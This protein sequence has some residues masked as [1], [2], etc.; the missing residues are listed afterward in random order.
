MLKNKSFFSEIPLL[1]QARPDSLQRLAELSKRQ[2]GKKGYL[3]FSQ[4]DIADWFYVIENGWVKLFSE[5]ING[6]EIILDLLTKHDIFGETTF[7]HNN[8]YSFHAEMIEPGEIWMIPTTW[9]QAEIQNYPPFA[10]AMMT[11]MAHLKTSRDKQIEHHTIQD[12]SQ[13]LACFLLRLYDGQKSGPIKLMLPIDKHLIANYLGMKPETFSRALI[14]LNKEL[15]LEIEGMQIRINHLNDLVTYT[16]Q[17][18]SDVFPCF[19]R[20][21]CKSYAQA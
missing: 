2:T 6:E 13:R 16:C 14:K 7:F 21:H 8:S 4:N 15:D 19:D 17:T 20:Q 18:C 10:M 11:H 5:T 9:I 12:A 1:K 3:F